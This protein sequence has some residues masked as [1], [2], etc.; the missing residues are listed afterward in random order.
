ML[1]R[2]GLIILALVVLAGCGADL[3]PNPKVRVGSDVPEG[4]ILYCANALNVNSCHLVPD[5]KFWN[6]PP[7]TRETG[8]AR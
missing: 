4:W 6:C 7:P 5:P 3:E 8:V 1:R 2:V